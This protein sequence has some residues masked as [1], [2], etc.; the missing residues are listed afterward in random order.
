MT[1]PVDPVNIKI[2]GAYKNAPPLTA[3]PAFADR[4][5]RRERF[6]NGFPQ[7]SILRKK[8]HLIFQCYN[9]ISEHYI[10]K[11]KC[12]TMDVSFIYVLSIGETRSDLAAQHHTIKVIFFLL[13]QLSC[14]PQIQLHSPYRPQSV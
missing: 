11:H 3:L 4:Q 1:K 13:I 7:I 14:P 10:H 2:N 12:G 6:K 9:H 5:S 8:I